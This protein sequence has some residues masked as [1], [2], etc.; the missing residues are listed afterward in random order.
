[1][2]MRRHT[3]W[4]ALIQ[5]WA[6]SHGQAA[7]GDLLVAYPVIIRWKFQ[8]TKINEGSNICLHY[9]AGYR[10]WDAPLEWFS[11]ATGLWVVPRLLSEICWLDIQW[12]TFVIIGWI[13]SSCVLSFRCCAWP[14]WAVSAGVVFRSQVAYYL[15]DAVGDLNGLY[16]RALCSGLKLRIIFQMLWVTWMGCIC[17]RCVQVSS[18]VLS[19]RCCGWPEWAVSAGVVFRSQ[20]A[21]YLSDAVGDLNGLYLRALCSGLKLRIIFQ[22][23]WVIWMGCICGRCVQVSSCV[24][25]FRCCGWPEWAVS[26]GVVFRS[27]VAYYLSDAVGDLNG[28]YLRA[29]CSGLKLRVIFQMLRVTW[30]GCI[31]LRAFCLGLKLRVIFQM[32]WVTWMGCICGRSVRVSSCVFSFRC[33]GW[34]EWAVSA[35]VLFGSQVACFLSDAAGDLNGLYLR[36]FCSG[37]NEV[38]QSYRRAL[39]DLERELLTDPHLTVTHIQAALEEVRE[40]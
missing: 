34:P 21:Y 27:Q 8:L 7:E 4:V 39:L 33:C 35:G 28:L 13:F 23:L 24:L 11:S 10:R 12:L 22:M 18:C 26:A 9:K 15:S 16:L 14:E 2:H 17:G 37:L 29:F 19:F 6:R 25:S 30:T 32:L 38:L 36:A 1:M 3:S 40:R 31:D 20:V 5:N